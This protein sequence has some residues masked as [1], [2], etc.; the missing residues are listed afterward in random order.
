ML[1][2]F[3]ATESLVLS[4]PTMCPAV[5][6]PVSRAVFPKM[7]ATRDGSG[8]DVGQ[9]LTSLQGLPV[10]WGPDGPLQDPMKEESDIRGYDGF[11]KF[12][13]ACSAAGIDL[14]QPDI[15]VMAPTDLTIDNFLDTPGATLTPDILNYHIV[16]GIVK[17]SEFSSASLVT[18][19]GG[20]LTYRRMFRKDFIDDA[21]PGV[22]PAGASKGN[23][24]PADL[25]CSNGII[26]G[27]NLVLQPG[28]TKHEQ[29]L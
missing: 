17:K 10:L 23:A 1:A 29:E 18:L 28:W 4:G 12:A 2:L 22:E 27:C 24:F 6:A 25:M 9:T 3:A 11:G 19:Q 14:S 7:C 21:T 15:T 5:M 20:S 13:A 16:K 8:G 26:H